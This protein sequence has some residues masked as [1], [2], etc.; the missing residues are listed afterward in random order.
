MNNRPITVSVHMITYNHEKYIVQAIES[1]LMQET[2]FRFEL[3]IG[4]D[5]STDRTREIVFEYAK[6]Y[7]DI[8]TVITSDK[9]IGMHKNSV[10]TLN[11]CH[12]KYIAFCEGDDYWTNPLKLQK[13]VDFLENHPDYGL[14]HSDID[15][16]LDKRKKIIKNLKKRD[17]KVIHQGNIYEDLLITNFINTCTVCIK[18]EILN[19]IDTKKLWVESPWIYGDYPLWLEISLRTKIGYIDGSFA[20]YRILE[21]SA[22]HTRNFKEKLKMYKNSYDMRFYYVK[23][24]GCSKKT[25]EKIYFRYNKGLL[26]FAFFLNDNQLAQ[27][28]YGFLKNNI[29][30]KLTINF[31]DIFYYLGTKKFFNIILHSLYFIQLRL[32]LIIEFIIIRINKEYKT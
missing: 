30:K 16:H 29:N 12:G 8:I 21:E 5:Y 11:S 25:M 20:T 1:V 10:R 4:E 9:N 22:A 6:E 26:E 7:P 23:N 27:K 31:K 2:N 15:L 14:V 32:K 28:S 17:F 19:Q 13:Q 18:S 3:V 24:Y